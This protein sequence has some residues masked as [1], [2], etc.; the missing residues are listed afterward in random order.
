[1][2]EDSEAL[3]AKFNPWVIGRKQGLLSYNHKKQRNPT[4]I[5][6]I[7]QEECKLWDR[8]FPES[9]KGCG[10]PCRTDSESEPMRTM[11]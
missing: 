6:E 3:N 1:M 11:K 5:Y 8:T 9:R 4:N 2:A 10:G 7:L